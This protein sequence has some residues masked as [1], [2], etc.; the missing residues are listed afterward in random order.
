MRIVLFGPPGA[1]KGTQAHLLADKFGLALIATGDI[2]RE[3][4]E[5]ETP[6][7]QQAREYMDAGELVPDEVVV[8][9]VLD[10]LDRPDAEDG[11]ILDGFPRTLIQAQALENALAER[12]RPLTAVLKFVVPDEVAVKRLAGRRTC[13]HCQRT[14]NMEFKTPR[15]DLLC[16]VCD[17]ELVQRPDDH[18][19]LVRHRLEVYHRE[20]E[21]LEFYFW[22]RGLLHEIDADGYLETVTD[23][24][25]EALSDIANGNGKP[26]GT[27]GRPERP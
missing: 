16:D 19:E 4:V 5:E 17:G 3:N 7:G 20:T 15:R 14:Y 11:F 25:I 13:R 1:G 8:Q 10:R 24:A 21:P 6:L 23:R 26:N 12:D 9:M 2:F 27:P 18:E 22:E